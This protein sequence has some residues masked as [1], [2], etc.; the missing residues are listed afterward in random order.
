MNVDP[1][2]LVEMLKERLLVVQQISAAQS[3]TLLNQQ[4]AGGAEFEIQRIE[5]EIAATGG[6]H[7]FAHAIEEEAHER[8]KEAK[9]GMLACDVQC[10]ALE[11]R[12]EELDRRIATGR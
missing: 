7:A 3:W 9:A 2:V 11:R 10:A 6:S 5:Q 12:L 1:E 4:L 8:L